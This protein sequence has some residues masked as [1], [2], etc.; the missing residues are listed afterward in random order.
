MAVRVA[1]WFIFCASSTAAVQYERRTHAVDAM[2][3]TRRGMPF[4]HRSLVPLDQVDLSTDIDRGQGVLGLFDDP[5]AAARD[6]ENPMLN[7]C[8]GMCGL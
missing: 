6:A 7:E 8:E 1:L 3:A 5:A 4:L 2:R